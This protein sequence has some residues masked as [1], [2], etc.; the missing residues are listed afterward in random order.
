VNSY[1][2]VLLVGFGG[3]EGP[4][5]VLA[6]MRNVTRG[7]DIPEQR[8]REVSAHYE[9]FGGVS[10]LN[11]Q[12]REL[13]L[14]LEHTLHNAGIELPVFW[15]NRNWHPLL[16][17]T[18]QLIAS[19]GHERVLAVVTSAFSSYSG[20]GQ[21]LD[22]ISAA[23]VEVGSSAP[24]VDKVRNYFNHPG[25]IN[26]Q[27]AQV[28]DALKF[29]DDPYLLFT[30]HS[31]PISMAEKCGYVEQLQEA[32][33]LVLET[34]GCGTGELVYQSRSGPPHVA[35][36]E[37]D[38]NDRIR[39][40]SAESV[41]EVVLVPIGFVSDHMEIVWDL[42]TQAAQTAKDCNVSLTRAKTVGTHQ[43]FVDGLCSMIEER[44]SGSAERV[45]IGQFPALPDVCA[46][47]CCR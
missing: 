9:H 20:C 41:N 43:A 16:T 12:L 17:D 42:D 26:A 10:P 3:P 29:T 5:D 6:F 13:R 8:L 40:L 45:A 44:I 38:I 4:D 19:T 14:K 1:D 32:M 28:H 2:A 36:L 35:W 15:G 30:A 25:F 18:L 27:A 24:T 22:D 39:T 7:K 34:L 46:E 37:P 47:G 31:L 21:Y 11:G 23:R 33:R